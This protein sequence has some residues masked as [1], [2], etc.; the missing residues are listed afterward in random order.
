MLCERV[1]ECCV[2]VHECCV[3]V[4]EC[5]S[6]G[7][8]RKEQ[9]PKRSRARA[10]ASTT[11]KARGGGGGG[12]GGRTHHGPRELVAARDEDCELAPR[13]ERRLRQRAADAVVAKHEQAQAGDVGD[14]L[15]HAAGQRVAGEREEG[16]VGLFV[17]RVWKGG[18]WWL[19]FLQVRVEA[20]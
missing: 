13:A 20:F 6:V 18:G 5:V 10:R 7:R 16:G 15:G 4:Y 11:Q 12:G 19:M 3:S 9:T 14:L 1:Y 8:R 17:V 2:S